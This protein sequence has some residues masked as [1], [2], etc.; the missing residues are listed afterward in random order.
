[1]TL[2]GLIA[3]LFFL[4]FAPWFIG[5]LVATEEDV[6]YDLPPYKAWLAGAAIIGIGAVFVAGICGAIIG[7][8]AADEVQIFGKSDEEK[9]REEVKEYKREQHKQACYLLSIE[10]CVKNDKIRD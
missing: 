3:A 4:A 1:M 10:R 7:L 2:A 8:K 9:H 6:S 5:M